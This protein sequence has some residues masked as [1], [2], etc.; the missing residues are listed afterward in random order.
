MNP[1]GLRPFPVSRAAGLWLG[2][3][4]I[5]APPGALLQAQDFSGLRISEIHYHPP[6]TNGVDGEA[7][8]FIELE[9]TGGSEL[10]LGGV[11]FTGISATFL[12]PTVLGAGQFL[13]LA[14]D[15][16]RFTELYPGVVPDGSYLGKLDNAGETIRLLDPAGSVITSVTYND[17]SPWPTRAD[18][19]GLSLQRVNYALDPNRA[20]N[21]IAADPTPG[22]PLP[23]E[24]FDTDADRM[25]DWWELAHGL[26]IDEPSDANADPDGD[27]LTNLAEFIA[28]TD[29]F[30]PADCLRF[31]SVRFEQTPRYR[32]IVLTFQAAAN[33][34]YS[35]FRQFDPN[36]C[37]FATSQF[38]ARPTNRV[39]TF[40]YALLP[41]AGT[42]FFHLATPAQ[43]PPACDGANGD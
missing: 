18:G 9:N 40:R 5:L 31:T 30:D 39:E 43:P 28:G 14:R 1:P 15:P 16:A 27:G 11:S 22:R 36:G 42:A 23:A 32:E 38:G 26:N 37:W 33:R 12:Y 29:P 20:A 13:V 8:E 2:L 19:G 34:S 17:D 35:L 6:G 7:F 25:P 21:W 4:G 10:E 41:G 24:L 3:I